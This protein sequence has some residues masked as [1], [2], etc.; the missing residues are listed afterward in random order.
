M[1][2]S[3]KHKMYVYVS[4]ISHTSTCTVK[5][6]ISMKRYIY[7]DDFIVYLHD[8]EKLKN[9]LKSNSMLYQN[10]IKVYKFI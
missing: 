9:S 5:L 7:I 6:Q 10:V 3:L 2:M 8:K 4:P 1:K